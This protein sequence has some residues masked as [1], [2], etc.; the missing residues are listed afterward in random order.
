MEAISMEDVKIGVFLSHCNKQLLEILDFPEL[1]KYI[2]SLPDVVV[3]AQNDEYVQDTGIQTIAAAVKSKKLTHVVVSACDAIT[4]MIRLRKALK[5]VGMNPYCVEVLNLREHCALPHRNDPQGATEKAKAMLLAAVDK[6]KLQA[7][8]ETLE[9]PINKS[10]LII[11]GGIAGIQSAIDLTDL[12]FQV[13]LVE[14]EPTLGGIAAKAGRF[15]PTDDCALCVQSPSCNLEGI[16]NTSRKCLYRSGFSELPN[17]SIYTNSHITGITGNPGD[18]QV[19]VE[20]GKASSSSIVEYYPPIYSLS[21]STV[22]QEGTETI[23]L[24]PGTII[25]ATGFE[26]FDISAV[27]EYNYGV[28][29]DVVTQLELAEM[30]DPF[31]PTNGVLLRH[32]DK[33]EAK[34]IVMIQC[35]GSRDQRYN[36]YCSSICCMI[37]LKHALMIKERIPDADVKMCYIDIRSWGREHEENYYEKARE[38]GVKFVKGRPTEV[39]RDPSTGSLVV[40]TEDALLGEF[41]SLEADLVVLST[42]FVPAAGTQEL[43][44]LFGLDLGDDGFFKEYNAKLRPTETKLRGI[45]ICGGATFPKDAP[46]TSLHASSAALKA[47]KFMT[48]GKYVKDATTA[49]IDSELCGDC[50]FCPVMC[51]YGAI[52]LEEDGD[53]IVATVDD[54]KCNSCGICAG[55]CPKNAIT[56]QGL[57]EDQI[58]AQITALLQHAPE[59]GTVL[60]FSCAECGF[61]AI[62]TA[63]MAPAEYPANV[64]VLKVPCTGTLKVHHFLSAFKNGADAV[65]VV[66]CK[67]DGCHYEV[68]SETAKRRVELTKKILDLYGLG[69]TRLEMFHNISIEGKDFVS[70]ANAMLKQAQ[71]L[72]SI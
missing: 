52:R 51:P 32:S 68:G 48:A 24:N 3:A 72:G 49:V 7:P 54:V 11:G 4:S 57:T 2:Q 17:L 37:G 64:R 55:T 58:M 45:Y 53:H 29:P 60:A 27:K 25:I 8:I 34:N 46:T 26:E 10:T 47:A 61:T 42:A 38:V 63:G 28:Y 65:M 36:A 19:T 22:A 62:D 43:A 18:Y 59:D 33:K 56:I 70:E 21:E 30:L 6:M 31:G 41:L 12:G 39:M 67:P 23:T 44:D 35:A 50:E 40:D 15:F 66:G 20:R 69:S 5:D 71:T 13:D 16:T 1:L 14:R 9:F